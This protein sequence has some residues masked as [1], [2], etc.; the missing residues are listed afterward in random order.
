[1]FSPA[2]GT[3]HMPPMPDGAKRLIETSTADGVVDNVETTS[4]GMLQNIIVDSHSLTVDWRRT[5][6]FQQMKLFRYIG[7]ENPSAQCNCNLNSH[8][9][10]VTRSALNQQPVRAVQMGPFN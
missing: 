9:P 4:G 6:F 5:G 3:D 1:M 2:Q 10:D 7:R 8:V